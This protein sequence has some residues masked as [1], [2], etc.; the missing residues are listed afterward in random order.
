MKSDYYAAPAELGKSVRCTITII[1]DDFPGIL[2][3]QSNELKVM[4]SC[5]V[6]TLLVERTGGSRGAVSCTFHTKDVTAIAG[7]DYTACSG[8]IVFADGEA[9][10]EIQVQILDDSSWE[11]DEMFKVILENPTSGAQ[12]GYGFASQPLEQAVCEVHII[13]DDTVTTMVEVVAKMTR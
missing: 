9:V 6:A 5:G 12:F 11:K 3:H 13:S 2:S 8:E 1:D 4:E 7:H 10:K